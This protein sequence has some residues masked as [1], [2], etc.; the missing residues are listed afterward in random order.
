MNRCVGCG[1]LLQS[2]DKEK[3]GYTKDISNTL[4]ERCFRIR[5]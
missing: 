1:S 2:H 5:H 3:E 4:C